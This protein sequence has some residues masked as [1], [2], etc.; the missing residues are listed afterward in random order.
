M[1]ARYYTS[2]LLKEFDFILHETLDVYNKTKDLPSGLPGNS[3]EEKRETANMLLSSVGDFVKQEFVP[4]LAKFDEQGC[5][6]NPDGSVTTPDG[7]KSV[8]KKFYEQGFGS[9]AAEAEYGGGDMPQYL[10]SCANE[11]FN[12]NFPAGATQGLTAGGVFVIEQFGTQEIKDFYLP[13]FNSGEWSLTMCLTEPNHGS[14]AGNAQTKAI[15]V[16][17]TTADS[18]VKL[19]TQPNGKVSISGLKQFITS[20]EH[21]LTSNI[22]HLVLARLPGAPEGSDGISLI[23][24]SKN[25]ILAD[26][27]LGENNG[28]RCEKIEEKMGIH[29]SATCLMSFEDAEGVVI[30]KLNEG[31]KAMFVMMNDERINVATQGVSTG[32]ISLQNAA[33][34]ATERAQGAHIIE[35]AQ[36]MA[37]KGALKAAG[38]AKEDFNIKAAQPVKIIEHAS[39]QRELIDIKA[40]LDGWRALVADTSLNLFIAKKHPEESVR[41]QAQAYVELM[42]PVLKACATDFGVTSAQAAIQLHGGMGFIKDTGVEQFYRDG[43]IATI[44]EG[45]NNI[46]SHDFT[47]RKARNIP[48]VSQKIMGEV[49]GLMNNPALAP[50]APTLMTAV[51]IFQETA[52]YIQQKSE[53]AKKGQLGNLEDILVHSRDFMNL[54]GKL[55]V[56]VEWLKMM[57]AAAPQAATESNG[58]SFYKNKMKL[59][60]YYIESIMLPQM[61]MLGSRIKAGAQNIHD[62]DIKGIVPTL[63]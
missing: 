21:D 25:K 40:Q 48:A 63:K 45:E 8:Y 30:G 12:T 47:F 13:K 62:I 37:Q 35:K 28:V 27:T 57:D 39:V 17:D 34:Y 4:L 6:R 50:L 20:G 52:G 26:G 32:E 36:E 29:G 54:F 16:I 11:M 2:D 46:Q 49:M 60:A 43:L 24:V 18:A 31:M 7:L 19:D 5:T 14:D 22:C 61:K 56:G 33:L 3:A 15:P 53:A 59:G 23:L 55:A 51:K 1:A 44:Y 41:Q 38:V 42:T 10:V 58:Q 9:M